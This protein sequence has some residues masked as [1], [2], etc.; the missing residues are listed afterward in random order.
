MVSELWREAG[1]PPLSLSPSVLSLEQFQ[2]VGHMKFNIH[3]QA[4][5]SNH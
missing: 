3:T 5:Q 4:E 1:K 2:K